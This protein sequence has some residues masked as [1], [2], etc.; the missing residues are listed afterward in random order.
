MNLDKYSMK[1]MYFMVITFVIGFLV[2]SFSTELSF[3]K[4]DNENKDND[5]KNLIG[6]SS[7]LVN[8]NKKTLNDDLKEPIIQNDILK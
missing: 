1:Y 8:E 2:I 6:D 3:A 5:D 4:I 7:S